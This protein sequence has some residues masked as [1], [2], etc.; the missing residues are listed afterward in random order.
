MKRKYLAI[1]VAL[2]LVPAAALALPPSEARSKGKKQ[3]ARAPA[4]ASSTPSLSPSGRP[5]RQAPARPGAARPGGAGA[6]PGTGGAGTARPAVTPGRPDGASAGN[7][8]S[9]ENKQQPS[10]LPSD[11]GGWKILP[12]PRDQAGKL[13]DKTADRRPG[14]NPDQGRPGGGGRRSGDRRPGQ[15]PDVDRVRPDIDAD[16]RDVIVNRPDIDVNRPDVNIN[17]PDV[18]IN[19][20]IVINRPVTNINNTTINQKIVNRQ[21]NYYGAR[22]PYYSDLH[23]HWQPT[24]WAADYQPSYS[25]YYNSVQSS[26]S[27][28]SIGGIG[29]GFV[30]PFVTQS[31]TVAVQPALDYSQPIHVP[32]P[33]QAETADDLVRSEQAVRRFDDAREVFRRGEYGRAHDLIDEAIKLLPS[34]PTLHQFRALVLLARDKYQEA[35]AAIYSVLAVGPG[36]DW[37][38]IS[39]LYDDPDR[40][41][42]QVR[43]L[44][45]Y[46]RMNP[47]AVDARF[48]L[49]YHSLVVGDLP[50]AERQLQV[51]RIANPT[52]RVVQDMLV[53]VHTQIESAANN[54]QR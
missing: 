35:A 52:D 28:F 1:G 30:N 5:D 10:I 29:I 2:L 32:A 18:D 14:F 3:A 51:V 8:S 31:T 26:G 47:E 49:G 54:P 41:I 40:Y 19:R 42:E 33:D 34:D 6:R 17:R 13:P 24:S 21:N 48:L 25:G 20:P 9:R 46:A 23:H 44:E 16:R 12:V 53:A 45:A 4:A 11:P 38:T 22:R 50:S 15:R 27:L 37:D 7:R 43:K 39:K 36:W